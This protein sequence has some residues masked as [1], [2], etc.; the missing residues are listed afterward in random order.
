MQNN[1]NK[2]EKNKTN[3]IIQPLLGK[4]SKKSKLSYQLILNM[5][6]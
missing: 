2:L 6:F 5:T 4:K 1:E 3:E